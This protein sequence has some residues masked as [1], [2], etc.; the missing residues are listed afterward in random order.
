MKLGVLIAIVLGLILATAVIGYFGVG[1]VLHAL[2]AIGW[3][4]FAALL[5]YSVLPILI[6]GSAWFVL[7]DQPPAKFGV[8]VWARMVRDAAAEHLPLSQFGGFVIGARAAILHGV[9]ATESFATTVVD[10][11]CELLAQI[12]FIGIGITVLVIR[13]GHKSAHDGLVWA[14]VV[15]LV[16]L[17]VGAGAFI[18]L[19]R[20]SGRLLEKLAERFLPSSVAHASAVA[21][22]MNALYERPGRIAAASAL[23]L[24]AW[25][26][27]ATGSWIALRLTGVELGLAEV[28]AI[29]SLLGAVRS[30]AFAAPMAIGVQEAGYALVGPLFGL[31]PDMA[32][33]LSLIKRARD[34]AIGLP[35]L[36]IWQ[37]FEA[38]KLI[39]TA[40]EG[41]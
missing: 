12:A 16:L 20:K 17:A 21:Q 18:V 10:A 3:H 39:G 25:T 1:Q 6:L 5:A 33:A 22:A 31:Q 28:L 14:S 27:S 9:G 7:A 11:T 37:G 34:L 30:A 2:A 26:A 24:A 32:L 13:L 19:Q 23:H 15:G 29:E 35:A 41:A 4:S 8:F 36:L 38:K 40:L